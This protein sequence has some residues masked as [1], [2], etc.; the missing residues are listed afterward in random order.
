MLY[1][2]RRKDK[3]ITDK[4][5]LKKILKEA[6][7]VT[8]A[9]VKDDEPY[10]VSLSHG[11][12]EKKNCIYFHSA[13]EGKKLDYMRV[14]PMIWGQA[15]LDHGYH[16]GECSHLYASVMFKGRVE[17]IDDIETKRQVFKTM[18]QQ[19]EPNPDTIMD[20]MV[21]SKGIPTT[22]V[23]RIN[24]EYMTGKKSVNVVL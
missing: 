13:S 11:Y 17:F 9:M 7:Y 12:D 14:N 15:M 16:V 6:S 10:L 4:E 24:L 5:K 21:N 1:H 8:L 19:L 20:D 3:E 22:V 2:I 23:G 18:I